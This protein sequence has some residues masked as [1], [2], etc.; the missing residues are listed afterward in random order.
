VAESVGDNILL[1]GRKLPGFTLRDVEGRTVRLDDFKGRVV[2]IFFGYT[3]C[4]DICPMALQRYA[5]LQKLLGERQELIFIFITTDPIHDSPEKL[6]YLTVKYGGNIVALT[7]DW[8]ELATV[9]NAYHVRPLEDTG[10]STYMTHSA[11]IYVGDRNHILR[12]IFTPEMPAEEMLR[13]I[14]GL[15]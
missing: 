14:Q 1:S 11:L 4:P 3:N 2:L 7:G 8:M 5:E 15:L 13:E 12:S 10:P 6:K 9:W